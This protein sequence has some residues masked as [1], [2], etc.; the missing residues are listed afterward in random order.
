MKVSPIQLLESDLHKISIEVNESFDEDEGEDA[1]FQEIVLQTFKRVDAFPDYWETRAPPVA[2]MK[3]RTYRLSLGVRT[4]PDSDTGPYRFEIV[5]NAVVACLPERINNLDPS[6]AARE[7]GLTMVYGMI[8]E[9]LVSC[10]ARMAHGIRLLPSVSFIGD[11]DG[12]SEATAKSGAVGTE[13]RP[14]AK[15]IRNAGH[16]KTDSKGPSRSRPRKSLPA[17]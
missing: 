7:Y 3:E 6:Q 9:Q 15:R 11:S 8:R 2:S 4:P 5:F 12:A 13:T 14:P 17:A 1:Q 10:T 16:L